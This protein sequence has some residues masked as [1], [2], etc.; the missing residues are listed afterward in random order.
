M[1][2]LLWALA[3]RAVPDIATVRSITEQE[4][5]QMMRDFCQAITEE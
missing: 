3:E 2:R 4:F 5:A 1:R